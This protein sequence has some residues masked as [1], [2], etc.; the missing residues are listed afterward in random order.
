MKNVSLIFFSE[1]HTDKG[2]N[3]LVPIFVWNKNSTERLWLSCDVWNHGN[4]LGC[5]TCSI[6]IKNFITRDEQSIELKLKVIVTLE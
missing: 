5:N 1:Y 4:S 6:C 3:L 2:K